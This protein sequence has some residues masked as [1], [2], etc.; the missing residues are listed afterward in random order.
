MNEHSSKMIN[1]LSIVIQNI[2]QY[3]EDGN[4]DDFVKLMQDEKSYFS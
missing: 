2:S 3:I 1:E 4:E